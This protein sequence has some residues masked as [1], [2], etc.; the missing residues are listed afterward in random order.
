MVRWIS[1]VILG[2]SCFAC[3]RSSVSA[4][5]STVPVADSTR[6]KLMR[7]ESVVYGDFVTLRRFHQQLMQEVESVQF[8]YTLL[9]SLFNVLHVTADSVIVQRLH[10]DSSAH[11]NHQLLLDQSQYHYVL[12]AD[13]RAQYKHVQLA[14]GI[15]RYTLREYGEQMDT[16]IQF[17]LDSLEEGGRI[18]AKCKTD[19]KSKGFAD[20]SKELISAYQPIS[21]LELSMK[22]LSSSILQLQNLQSRFSEANVEEYFFTGPNLRPRRDIMVKQ[23]IVSELVLHMSDIRKFQ[24]S[25]YAQFI[26]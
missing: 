1:I 17:W 10:F 2:L 22:N 13:Q 16:D 3:Q 8:P 7:N 12:Y 14:S 15:Q 19:L 4:T 18:M 20:K 23:G 6:V 9:D 21:A 11:P 26:Q 24:K 5:S 25:Y